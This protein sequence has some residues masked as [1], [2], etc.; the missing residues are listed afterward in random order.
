MGRTVHR[1][2]FSD[3]EPS[4]RG[5][6]SY[7]ANAGAAVSFS[8]APNYF[9]LGRYRSRGL[10][11]STPEDEAVQGVWRRAAEQRNEIAALHVG[12][13]PSTAEKDR[14]NTMPSS[15]RFPAQHAHA[16]RLHF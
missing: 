9:S 3:E 10:T 15:I 13:C 2:R 1:D 5:L 4:P 8:P 14:F 11:K 7:L 12:P 6:A 16:L